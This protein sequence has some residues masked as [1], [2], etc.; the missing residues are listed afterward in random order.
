MIE[1]SRFELLYAL[2]W[3]IARLGEIRRPAYVENYG[4]Q[5]IAREQ[6]MIAAEIKRVK[7]ELG[8]V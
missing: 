1:V 6:R 7:K 3:L 8:I 4:S 5:V 2:R